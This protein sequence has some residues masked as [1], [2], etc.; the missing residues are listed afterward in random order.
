MYK[1]DW[2]HAR[3]SRQTWRDICEKGNIYEENHNLIITPISFWQA[4][5]VIWS[6]FEI[7]N[8]FLDW[9]QSKALYWVEILA[10]A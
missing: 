6:E 1:R 2:F 4:R 8:H 5:K 10:I 7:L 9:A 3:L